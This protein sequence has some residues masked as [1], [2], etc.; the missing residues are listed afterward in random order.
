[1]VLFCMF[2]LPT[3]TFDNRK[4]YRLFRK[5]LLQEGFIMLEESVYCRMIPNGN[6]MRCLVENVRKNRPP[7]GIVLLLKVTEHQFAQME[8]IV[9]EFHSDVVQSTV[10][11]IEI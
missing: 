6:A 10:P 2:D 11:V 5:F 4:N 3:Q 1:M 8:F 7:D 9:G